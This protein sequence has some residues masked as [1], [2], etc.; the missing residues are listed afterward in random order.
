MDDIEDHAD[1]APGGQ[2]DAVI[3]I[4]RGLAEDGQRLLGG[5]PQ[6]GIRAH[7]DDFGHEPAGLGPIGINRRPQALQR[8]FPGFKSFHHA[9]NV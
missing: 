6:R 2:R 3:V 9:R 1:A 7:P 4:V 8:Q 5:L